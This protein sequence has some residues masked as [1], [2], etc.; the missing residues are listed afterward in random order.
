MWNYNWILMA[1][2]ENRNNFRQWF[3]PAVWNAELLMLY[4]YR[5]VANRGYAGQNFKWIKCWNCSWC[6]LHWS[7]TI[8]SCL[9]LLSALFFLSQ[10]ISQSITWKKK[11]LLCNAVECFS[12][13]FRKNKSLSIGHSLPQPGDVLWPFDPVK[14]VHS[15]T[16][17]GAITGHCLHLSLC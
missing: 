7:W 14:V 8:V 6:C 15:V 13:K 12:E 16:T 1:G 2:Y 9:F 5:H 3:A 10:F 17:S 11:N 4:I